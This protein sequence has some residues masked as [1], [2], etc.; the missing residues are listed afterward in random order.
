M[1]P[2]PV[3][4]GY[5]CTECNHRWYY[6]KPI[7]PN[8]GRNTIETY[9]LDVGIVASTTVVH[10]TSEGVRSPNWLAFAQFGEVGVIAQVADTVDALTAGDPV[11]FAGEHVLRE[12]DSETII[13]PRLTATQVTVPE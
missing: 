8:C 1:T 10:T 6:T 4:C 9:E 11:R 13:G 7:C 12:T 2:S 5:H 3:D